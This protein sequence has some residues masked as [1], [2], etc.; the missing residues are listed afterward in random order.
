MKNCK[1]K[2]TE[3]V[4]FD[5]PG[6]DLEVGDDGA[7]AAR[8]KWKSWAETNRCTGRRMA[9][10]SSAASSTPSSAT[11]SKD[12]SGMDI[13]SSSSGGDEG[14]WDSGAHASGTGESALDM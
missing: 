1:T 14:Q 2:E 9:T 5:N 4:I 10:A 13:N 7:A 12:M 6:E 11:G 3:D 8:R